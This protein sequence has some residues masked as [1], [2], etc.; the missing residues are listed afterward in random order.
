MQDTGIGVSHLSAVFGL[1]E[2]CA[3]LDTLVDVPAFRAAW[4]QYCTLYNATPEE[5]QAAVGASF[6][7]L[8]LWEAHSRLTAYAAR[9]TGDRALAAR[10]WKEFYAGRAGYGVK[11]DL[12]STRI[13]GPAV[14]NPVDENFGLSTNAS[15]QWGCT[16]IQ[17]LALVGDQIPASR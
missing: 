9:Q 12:R 1:P 10:A 17:L 16:A 14:L 15:S 13:S 11:P 6:G 3:E 5:Q 4:L 2:L 8:N 7:R